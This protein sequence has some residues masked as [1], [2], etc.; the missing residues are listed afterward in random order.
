MTPSTRYRIIIAGLSAVVLFLVA[1][2]AWSTTAPDQPV[3]TPPPPTTSAPVATPSFN[4]NAGDAE[5]DHASDE[6]PNEA[7]W[8]PVVENFGRN[9]TNVTGGA[10]AWRGRLTGDPQRPLVTSEVTIQLG[11]VDIVNI[12]AGRYAGYEIQKTSAYDAAV[13]INYREG[14]SM[15]LYLITDGTHWQVY[16]YDRFEQ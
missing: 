4:E 1:A 10:A 8:R 5:H 13:K 15:V 3:T 16:A 12:P 2:L 6:D 11:T 14:W 7:A 9:F